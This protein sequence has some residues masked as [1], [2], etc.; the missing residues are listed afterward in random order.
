MFRATNAIAAA[1][2]LAASALAQEAAP[3]IKA[4]DAAAL[5][6]A[7]DQAVVVEGKVSKAE[8]SGTGKVINIEFEGSTNFV[9]AAFEKS[10]AKLDES[11]AGDFAKSMTGAT[12][13]L[14]GTL[15]P[16]GGRAEGMKNYLQIVIADTS[17]VTVVEPAGGT[18][19]PQP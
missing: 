8:W 17:Q 12:V 3:V 4:T 15:K 9:A 7:K 18:Q 16:Y 6:A 5:V 2:L 19:D 1:F 11:F 13:R 10:R 14:S